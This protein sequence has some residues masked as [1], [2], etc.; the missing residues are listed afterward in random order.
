MKK[1]SQQQKINNL[2]VTR[3]AEGAALYNKK[4]N[5]FNFCGAY[6]GKV[7]DKIGAGDAML[8][9]VALCLKSNLSRELSLLLGSLAAAQLTETIGNKEAVNRNKILRVLE[10]LFK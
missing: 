4:D 1:L 6:A 5:N 10:T 3:G 8:S 7:I 2:V 9:I